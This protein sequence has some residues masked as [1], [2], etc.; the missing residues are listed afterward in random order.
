MKLLITGFG[1]FPG[2]PDNPSK[3]LARRVGRTLSSA[4]H[5]QVTA[6]TAVLPTEW[7]ALPRILEPL[8]ARLAPDLIIHFGLHERARSF[9]IEQRAHNLAAA[10]PDAQGEISANGRISR[11]APDALESP[12]CA[13]SIA[14]KL[15][16]RGLPAESS[17]DAG[18]YL[19]N[20]A[21][22]LSLARGRTA[23]AQTPVLFVHIPLPERVGL[24]SHKIFDGGL[25][26]AEGAIY[27]VRRLRRAAPA[28]N[29]YMAPDL[30]GSG[31]NP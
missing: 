7:R 25:A 6:T 14:A 8:S 31:I 1:P 26:A 11:F 17:Y 13:S 12:L 5:N 18:D 15:R 23:A 16:R 27:Q 22:F 29:R 28:F 9:H 19:C 3:N 24:T 21:Y 30:L 4:S 10:R 20:M 2:V